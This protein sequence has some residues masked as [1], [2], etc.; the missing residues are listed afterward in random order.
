MDYNLETG[1]LLLF[2]EKKDGLFGCFL[3]MIQWGNT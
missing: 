3:S 1:D 2:T